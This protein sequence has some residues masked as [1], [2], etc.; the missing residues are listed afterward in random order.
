MSEELKKLLIDTIVNDTNLYG[1]I[2]ARIYPANMFA[3]RDM[4]FPC[5][6]YILAGGDGDPHAPKYF[7]PR[8]EFWIFSQK[9][10]KECWEIYEAFY[11]LIAREKF[12]SDNLAAQ[13]QAPDYPAE[14]WDDISKAFVL[15]FSANIN[16]VRLN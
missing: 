1:K 13:M 2:S 7:I 11:D 6:N 5:I 3:L 4:T 15:I 12:K 8:I 16:M 10:Y 9:H 14:D